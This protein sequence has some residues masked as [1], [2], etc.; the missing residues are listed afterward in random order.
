M[1]RPGPLPA[2]NG[3]NRRREEPHIRLG[4]RTTKIAVTGVPL[5]R[6]RDEK[7]PARVTNPAITGREIGAAKIAI[8]PARKIPEQTGLR[9]RYYANQ[10]RYQHQAM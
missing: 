4:V 9:N 2:E 6:H 7:R 5:H 1:A 10:M 3:I 8:A